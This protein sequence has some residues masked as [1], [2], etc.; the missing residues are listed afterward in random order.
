MGHHG[1]RGDLL[2]LSAGGDGLSG[3]EVSLT[4]RRQQCLD[5]RIVA[6]IG[7]ESAIEVLVRRVLE[8]AGAWAES[9]VLPAVRGVAA[10]HRDSLMTYL[11]TR[12][13][14]AEESTSPVVAWTEASA[15]AADDAYGRLE[16]A[17]LHLS[18]AFSYASIGY[19]ALFTSALRLYDED[20]RELAPRHQNECAH[21]A[22][23]LADVLPLTVVAELAAQGLECQCVCPMCSLG[24]CGCVAIG[25]AAATAPLRQPESR[26]HDGGGF[27]VQ[28][29]RRGSQLAESGVVAGDRLVA[30]DDEPVHD[31]SDIQAAIRRHPLGETMQLLIARGRE[32]HRLEA[33]HVH[34]YPS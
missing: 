4:D 13:V 1:A 8:L 33:T 25:R 31:V 22:Y 12:V 18:T 23:V 15:D 6:L 19:A 28:S 34:D 20:L 24:V 17:L 3:M 11:G 7:V 27:L 14:P 5:R 16:S 32:Q 30:I 29:P 21:A 26:A 10:A 9:S 2:A